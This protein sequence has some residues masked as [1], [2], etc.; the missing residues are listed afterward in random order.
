MSA[1]N[2]DPSVI[3]AFD[4]AAATYDAASQVQRE[5]A[6]ELV[7]RAGRASAANPAKVL[8]L[9]SGAGH[10]T[11][12]ARQRWPEAEMTAL[13]A[14]PAMLAALRAKF[15]DVQ[16]I[17]ADAAEP[18]DIGRFDLILS[19]MMAHWL[20]EPRQALA[21]WR[22]LLTPGGQLHL[23]L[24]VAGSLEEWRNACKA[25]N[26]ADGLWAFPEPGFAAGLCK[27]A[28]TSSFV[29]SYA[30]ARTFLQG[31]KRT[32][33][34]MSRPGHRPA[35]PAALRRLLARQGKPFTVTFKIE[36]LALD[37]QG[38]SRRKAAAPGEK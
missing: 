6:R 12:F 29:A 38:L 27:S 22:E 24:P 7:F 17:Q 21:Q 4:A 1:R 26:L 5:I 37:P 3:R 23:A 34:R 19:S 10:V 14:A 9:G 35:S 36:F 33:A 31:F 18:G 32:G 30:D 8:D 2:T 25:E 15:P 28:E 11:D 20:P 16:I 13:D